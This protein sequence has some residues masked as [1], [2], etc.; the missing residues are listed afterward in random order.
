[1]IYLVFYLTI[2]IGV[3]AG[4]SM[5]QRISDEAYPDQLAWCRHT[6]Y[7]LQLLII[8]ILRVGLWPIEVCT[9]TAV[10]L[11]EGC[12][13]TMDEDVPF[14]VAHS[15]LVE[16]LSISEIEQREMVTDPLGAVPDLPFGHLHPAWKKFVEGVKPSDAIWSFSMEWKYSWGAEELRAGYVIVRN[17]K[18]G[19]YILTMCR[20]M[21][22]DLNET[23]SW[24]DKL[25]VSFKQDDHF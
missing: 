16:R 11:W 12:G 14:S 25:R 20:W 21:Q 10:L 13:R 17:D 4:F 9:R 19:A 24:M 5:S 15:G 7:D 6:D 18:I 8:D 23:S 1:M 22:N 2:G 3:V